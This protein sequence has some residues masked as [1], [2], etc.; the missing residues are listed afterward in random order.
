VWLAAPAQDAFRESRPSE[1]AEPKQ[2]TAFRVVYDAEH[3]YVFVRA[4]DTH[5]DSIIALLSRRDVQ[6]ASDQIIVM[7]DSYHDRRTGYEFVTN[8]VGVKADYAIYNDGDE[9]GAWDAVWDVATK[10]DSLGWSA[11]YRIPFSQLRFN[12]DDDVTFG[13]LV[14]RTVQRYT[15]QVTWPHFRPSET[16]FVSQFGQLTGLSGLAAPRRAEL[17][18]YVLTQN[19]PFAEPGGFDRRQKIS[20]GGDLKYA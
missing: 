11:E 9:D 10:I 3:L 6:T 7:I 4:W 8:P 14:W 20:V 15:S 19:E 13:F 5:P 1:G 17:A 2:R 16:G 12:P 18:P